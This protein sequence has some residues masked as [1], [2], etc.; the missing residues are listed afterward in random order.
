MATCFHHTDRETGRACTR[1]GRPACPDC[2]IQASVGSH[3]WECVKSAAPPRSQ[4]AKRF[5]ASEQLLVTKSIIAI[6]IAAYV[7]SLAG[8]S[9]NGISEHAR[10]LGLYGPA[11]ADGE[12][13]RLVSHTLV[14]FTLLHIGFNMFVLYQVGLLLEPAAGRLRFL[15]LYLVSVLGGAAGALL[16]DPNALTGGASGGVFGVAAAATLTMYRNG[17]RFSQTAFGPLLVVNLVLGF[18]IDNVSVG[19]HIGGLVAGL[20]ATEAM[21][22]ARKVGQPWLGVAGAVAVGAVAVVIALAAADSA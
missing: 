6:T 1:C 8:E 18:V 16:L 4:R 9:V 5:V 15:L 12:W 22:Q 14:H 7:V 20:A 2:L 11:V 10:D 21:L 3:C 17:Q 19:G 13:Y